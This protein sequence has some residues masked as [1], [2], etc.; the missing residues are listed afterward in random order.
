MIN[1]ISRSAPQRLSPPHF[2]LHPLLYPLLLRDLGVWCYDLNDQGHHPHLP[3]HH[4]NHN[5][6]PAYHPHAPVNPNPNPPTNPHHHP[7]LF[8]LLPSHPPPPD[9]PPPLFHPSAPKNPQD[10]Q[11]PPDHHCGNQIL[12]SMG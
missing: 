11:R 2:S 7:P 4:H 8:L 3:H 1:V 6:P 12:S 10:P 9:L 5:P